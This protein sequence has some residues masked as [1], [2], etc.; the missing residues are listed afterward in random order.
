MQW[1]NIWQMFD[2]KVKKHIILSKNTLEPFY[3]LQFNF[4]KN[5]TFIITCILSVLLFYHQ[6]ISL[7]T[8]NNPRLRYTTFCLSIGQMMDIWVVFTIWLLWVMLWTLCI[9][10][11]IES[12]I[13]AGPDRSIGKSHAWLCCRSCG[14]S[15]SKSVLGCVQV[16][17]EQRCKTVNSRLLLV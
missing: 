8:N 4:L 6:M 1:I 16:H 17:Q 15:I 10:F 14:Q 9:S 12:Q 2:L 11:C 13:W 7:L 3:F 5:N